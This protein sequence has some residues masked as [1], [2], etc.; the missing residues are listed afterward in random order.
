MSVETSRQFVDTNV[1][2]YAHDDSAGPKRQRARAL[3]EELWA[4]RSGCVSIQVLQEVYITLTGKVPKRLEAATATTIVGDLSRWRVHAPSAD[5]VL[6]AIALHRRHSIRFWD[7]MILWS[8]TQL[9]C[10][11]LWSED[12]NP[13]QVY[14]GVQVLNP[15]AG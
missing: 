7:A 11:I 10:G 12:L 6:R 15:F 13:G 8:A 4:A 5:D 14:D 3:I 9:G 1:V 2:V